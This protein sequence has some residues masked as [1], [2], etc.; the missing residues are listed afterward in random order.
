MQP[1]FRLVIAIQLFFILSSYA[2]AQQ[3]APA[4]EP[5]IFGEELDVRVVNVEVVVTDKQGNRVSGLKPEDFRLRVDGK[6]VP[7]EYFTEVKEGRVTAP[8][9][10]DPAKVEAGPAPVVGAEGVV[11]TWYLVFVDDYFPVAAHRNAVLKSLKDDLGRLGPNDRM[12]VVA[13]NGGRLSMVS[14]WSGSRNQLERA[15]DQAMTRPA[16]GFDRI[17]ELRE[18]RNDESFARGVTADGGIL[19]LGVTSTGLNERESAYADTLVR[20]VQAAVGATVSTMRG[21]AAPEGRKVLLLLSGGWPFSPQT[22]VRANIAPSRSLQDGDQLFRRLTN[23]ANLLGYTIYPV[24]V[25]GIQREAASATAEGPADLT[26]LNLSEQEVEGTLE[27]IATETGGRSLVNSN[28]AI[29]LERANSDTR[30][31]YLLGFSPEW[32][33]NDKSHA[34]AVEVRRPGLKVRSRTGFLDLSRKAEVSMKVESALLFGNLPDALPLP[35][36]LGAVQRTKKGLEVPVTLGLPVN[37]MTVVP[38]NGKY[39]AQLELR[40]IAS[41]SEGNNSEIPVIPI[42]LTSDKPPTPGKMVKYETKILLR[43]GKAD[44]LVAAVYDPLSGKIATAEAKLE[45]TKE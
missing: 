18:F 28:R 26:A 20:Q 40:F 3:Q 38:V 41:D 12:A 8:A 11:P 9:G 14:S 2:M 32:K 23:T 29:A 25:P 44:Q 6:D 27:F 43:R 22:V 7:V 31:Y 15:F 33:R 13:W 39:A 5:P 24:D 36:K 1:W 45:E 37:L 16:H 19:D 34:M 10:S 17:R 21:F 4:A 35:M 30:S 42:N